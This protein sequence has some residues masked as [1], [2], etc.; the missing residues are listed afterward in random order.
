MTSHLTSICISIYTPTSIGMQML[1]LIA[2]ATAHDRRTSFFISVG[3]H[4]FTLARRLAN[5]VQMKS[6]TSSAVSPRLLTS[7]PPPD[8][9]LRSLG[10]V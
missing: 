6:S 3:S 4:G 8:L 9:G 7:V 2:Q 5:L 1:T 10:S